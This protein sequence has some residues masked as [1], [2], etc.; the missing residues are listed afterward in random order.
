MAVAG[1]IPNSLDETAKNEYR[2]GL[3]DEV[4]A[5]MISLEQP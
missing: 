1:E 2:R 5:D 3:A 4:V